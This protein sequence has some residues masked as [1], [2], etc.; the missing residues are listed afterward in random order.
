MGRI[1]PDEVMGRIIE[2]MK[3]LIVDCILSV[4]KFFIRN[5]KK[6]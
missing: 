5:S 2:R 1:D 4:R 3:N 6:K